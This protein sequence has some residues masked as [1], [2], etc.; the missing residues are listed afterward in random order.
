METDC[1]LRS[2]AGPWSQPET[3]HPSAS[4]HISLPH[5]HL[6]T[7]LLLVL[8]CHE[9]LPSRTRGRNSSGYIPFIISSATSALL[10]FPMVKQTK[11][12]VCGCV[13]TH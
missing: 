7:I 4:P 2:R 9:P 10:Y 6:V 3:Q 1:L 8:L 13:H 11:L 5:L 12:V